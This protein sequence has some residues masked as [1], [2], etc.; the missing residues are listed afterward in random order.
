[1][2][3]SFLSAIASCCLL[4]G[5]GFAQGFQADVQPLIDAVCIRCHDAET[6]T[7][8]QLEDLGHDLA[9]PDTYRD[10]VKVF[11]RVQGREMPPRS[12][13]RPPRAL[14]DKALASLKGALLKANLAA[15]QDQRVSLRRL[16]RVEYEYTLND[17]L[18]IHDQLGKLLAADV[19]AAR[20][21]TVASGQRISA[22][23]VQSYLDTATRALDSAIL[24]GSRPGSEPRLVDYLNS[25]Y[26]DRWYEEPLQQGGSLIKKMDGAVG[27]FTDNDWTLRSNRAGFRVRYPGL[28]RI[29]AEAYAYQAHSPVTLLLVQGSQQE[30]G[31][32]MLGAFDLLPGETR[33][34]EITAFLQP[35]DFLF[36]T[37]DDADWGPDRKRIFQSKGGAKTYQ[38]EG[39][40]FKSLTVQG[41]LA[42]TWPPQ[43]TR[44]LLTGVEFVKRKE[45]RW[46]SRRAY[47][48]KLSKDPLDHI[49]DM[50]ARIAP[51]AFRRPPK[52]GEVEFYTRLA[53]PAIAEGRDFVDAARVPLSAILSSPQFLFH[54]GRPGELNDFALASRLSYF[55][56]KSMPDEK[57]FQLA[58]ERRLSEPDILAAQVD[59]MLGDEK[60]MRF[61]KDFI[62]QWL[63]LN[64][65]GATTPDKRLYREYDDVL[66]QAIVRET[67]LFF[68]ELVA[69]DL[70]IKNII[71][72]DFTFLNR[73]LAEHYDIPGVKGQQMRKMQLPENSPRGGVLTHASILKLTANGTVTSPI[74]R[75]NFVVT[76]LLGQ[77][78]NPPPADVTIEEP[79]TRGTTT[80]REQ[81]DK[82]RNLET[83]ANCHN[84]I[85]PP[86]FAMESFDPIG[87]FRTRY[88]TTDWRKR[89]QG[90]KVDASGITEDGEPFSGIRE[91][92]VLLLKKEDEVARH[93]ISQLVIYA[94]GGEVQFADREELSRIVKQTKTSGYPVRTIIHT[95]VQSNLFRNK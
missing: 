84:H 56:W 58:R 25:V 66:N 88:R 14:V 31:S 45:A 41:P 36:P 1:M 63:R 21:D 34:V 59:R 65:I 7:P 29:T 80:I 60:S 17:L 85:D 47:T 18:G 82:H 19:D 48:V 57:L 3:R 2:L 83:C 38:G 23:H 5:G 91:F 78:P 92:K 39:I 33:T 75:G 79:D 9:N 71:D 40:G 10:W 27:I 62:G 16:S 54:S 81:L 76:N 15:R 46:N 89:R 44:Q 24:L 50:I 68:A 90:P 4:A 69:Q 77:P 11:D 70:P 30:G 6:T 35:Y 95:I 61:I 37:I 8:L 86:G 52:K 43:S 55:L 53:E 28:Y 49:S 72:S 64:E 42:E 32:N 73:R 93:F 87:G 67:E 13:P 12:E 22:I 20:F 51:L 74:K 94:T 26:V